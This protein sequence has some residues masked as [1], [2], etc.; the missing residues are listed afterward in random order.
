M[1]AKKICKEHGIENGTIYN[2]RYMIALAV[3]TTLI[4]LSS[5]PFYSNTILRYGVVILLVVVCTVIGKKIIKNKRI[6]Q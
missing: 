5:I 3:I 4:S 2:D 1:W 6:K